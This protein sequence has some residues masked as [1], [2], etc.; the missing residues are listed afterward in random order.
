MPRR[1]VPSRTPTSAHLG[2]PIADGWALVQAEW[3]NQGWLAE[4]SL[5]RW[6]DFGDKFIARLTV[7]GLRDWVDVDAEVCRGFVTAPTRSGTAPR[8]GTQHTRRAALRAI[9]RTLRGL[10]YAVGDPTLDVDLPART[11]AVY[12]PLTDDEIQL[13]RAASRLGGGSR[14]LL[15]AVAWALAEAG[16]ASSEIG[17]VRLTDLDDP[18]NPRTV[19][20]AESLRF[21]ARTN[22]L[23]DWGARVLAR[24]LDH[25][26]RDPAASLAYAGRD[27]ANSSAY[28][29]QASV[30]AG[31]ARVLDL[32][33]LRRDP[34]VR[35]RSIRGWAG[36]TRYD[37]GANLTEVAAFLGYRSL[38]GAAAEIGLTAQGLP[39]RSRP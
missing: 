27:P 17:R 28:L 37:H 13:G 2:L 30:C 26:D 22:A 11:V 29:A 31:L 19:T 21:A 10:G 4:Q 18:G 6:I 9:F 33:D 24:H 16:A 35:P 39:T 38:D 15:R 25:G 5:A 14:T 3:A 32:A 7:I 8:S 34:A 23:T 1:V 20:F 12:R 36:R